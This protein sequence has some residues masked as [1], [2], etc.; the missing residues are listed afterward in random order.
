MSPE[1]HQKLFNPLM[2]PQDILKLYP[3]AYLR[4]IDRF[5]WFPYDILKGEKEGWND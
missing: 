5:G 4:R 2:K 1:Y 3:S